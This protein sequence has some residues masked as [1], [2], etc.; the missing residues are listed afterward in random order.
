[1]ANGKAMKLLLL[2][3]TKSIQAASKI[4]N[5]QVYAQKLE[6][7]LNETN[8]ILYY[9][10]PFAKQ[11]NYERYLADANLFMEFISILV[12]SWQW[13]EIAVNASNNINNKEAKYSKEF[14]KSKIETMKFFYKYE[15][16]K[17][18]ALVDSII[19]KDAITIKTDLD[20]FI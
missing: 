7:K 2:E 20:I 13:L 8:K 16:V 9:L 14:Y 12:V 17:T 18:T 3:I 4:D 15:L 10:L 6:N 5:L 19:N 1:M 11:G